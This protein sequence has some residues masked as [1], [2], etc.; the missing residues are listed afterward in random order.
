[1][2]DRENI[3]HIKTCPD[4]YFDQ[5]KQYVDTFRLDNREMKANEF[6]IALIHDE[7][8]GFGR[9]RE[10]GSCSELC[11]L[12]VVVPH[13]KKGI[14]TLLA[15]ALI[16]KAQKELYLAT[17]IPAFFKRLHFDKVTCYPEALND[18]ISYC[19][20]SLTV[21]EEYC[22]MKHQNA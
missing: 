7:L 9:I 2:P 11:S 6:L 14:G 21:P 10:Y 16:L 8:V 18:K 12:G 20:A 5:V 15:K 13:S 3:L 22:V 19:K 4:T 1:M 17:V